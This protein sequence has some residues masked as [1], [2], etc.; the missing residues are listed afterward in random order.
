[1]L[2]QG[3]RA[4]ALKKAL[5]EESQLTVYDVPADVLINHIAQ[6]L[7]V[8]RKLAE[9]AF[10]VYA[11]SGAHRERAPSHQ[12]W[13]FIRCASIL[14]RLYVDG[15]SGVES[16]R[17]YYGGTRNRGVRP[18]HIKKAGGKVI[19]TCLQALEKDGL[20]AKVKTGGRQVSPSGEKYLNLMSKDVVLRLGDIKKEAV[21]LKIERDRLRAERDKERKKAKEMEMSFSKE[22]KK[23][24]AAKKKEEKKEA[25]T[26]KKS[27][28]KK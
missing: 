25:K 17:S 16:L 9:P 18:K 3:C 6:D 24:K 8:K 10:T 20:L 12:D 23:A 13:W 22:A 26:K 2:Q 15:P 5:K 4:N 1:L 19:R 14:R 11:K 21:K 27:T 28:K 7:K